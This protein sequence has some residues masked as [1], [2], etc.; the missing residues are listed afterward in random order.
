MFFVLYETEQIVYAFDAVVLFDDSKL[1]PKQSTL[2]C[3]LL[4]RSFKRM[5]G[6]LGIQSVFGSFGVERLLIW[7]MK[8]K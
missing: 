2:L 8:T 4:N 1:C 3:K 7:Y 6:S 5:N